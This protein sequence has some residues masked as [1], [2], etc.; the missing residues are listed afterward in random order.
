V[1]S[2]LLASFQPSS[3]D[4]LGLT[5]F[6]GD[7]SPFILHQREQTD[8]LPV[9]KYT[10][11]PLSCPLYAQQPA[12]FIEEPLLI[13]AVDQHFGF[14][15]QALLP[16]DQVAVS[17]SADGDRVLRREKIGLVLVLLL[18]LCGLR[19]CVIF[20][21]N[22]GGAMYV[23]ARSLRWASTWNAPRQLGLQNLCAL[24]PVAAQMVGDIVR[25]WSRSFRRL[26]TAALTLIVTNL[27]LGALALV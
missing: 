9:D 24:P 6:G 19:G 22:V 14:A 27:P 4:L 15:K 18:A 21:G 12:K 2:S 23:D 5:S 17:V 25:R 1:S 26:G 7:V 10:G 11:A 8:K 20:G 13:V 16:E 3:G